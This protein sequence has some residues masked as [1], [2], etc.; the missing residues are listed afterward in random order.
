M[1]FF[2]FQ[3]YF[4][5]YIKYTNCTFLISKQLKVQHRLGET[6]ESLH[7][8]EWLVLFCFLVILCG[9]HIMH[10]PSPNPLPIPLCSMDVT[11]CLI[12]YPSVH[13][14]SF[15]NEVI[16]LIRDFCD[17]INIASSKGFLPV[18]LLLLPCVMKIL[19]L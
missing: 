17:S 13:T 3:F 14:S 18:I 15:A 9:F 1:D 7:L 6:P 4:S 19:K 5:G 10:H 11:V 8:A 2:H 12:V 16:C